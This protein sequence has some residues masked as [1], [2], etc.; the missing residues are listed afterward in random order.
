[1]QQYE[2]HALSCITSSY[3]QSLER[4]IQDMNAIHTKEMK[5]MQDKVTAFQIELARDRQVL[6]MSAEQSNQNHVEEKERLK[7]QITTSQNMIS[8]LESRI[9][10]MGPSFNENYGYN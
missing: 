10:S 2:A 4:K 3:V 6:T 5:S 7:N 9:A 1:M 8:S